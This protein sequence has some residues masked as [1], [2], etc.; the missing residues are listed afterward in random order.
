MRRAVTEAVRASLATGIR[1]V[2]PALRPLARQAFEGDPLTARRAQR[3]TAEP[4]YAIAGPVV[5]D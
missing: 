3:P 5:A 2:G 4:L 1:S